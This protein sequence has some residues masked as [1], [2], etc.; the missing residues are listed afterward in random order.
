MPS[1]KIYGNTDALK[2]ALPKNLPSIDINYISRYILI[3]EQECER[4]KLFS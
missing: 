4:S 3:L 2:N 1:Y